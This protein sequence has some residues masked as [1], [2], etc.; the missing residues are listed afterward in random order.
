[1][2]KDKR[3]FELL[4]FIR[5]GIGDETVLGPF[6]YVNSHITRALEQVCTKKDNL[7]SLQWH[8]W[9]SFQLFLLSHPS[10][11]KKTSNMDSSS[12]TVS[13]RKFSVL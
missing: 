9:Y 13:S 4:R 11:L 5:M 1:M 6:G 12:I 10:C 7:L 8:P 3:F 2:S